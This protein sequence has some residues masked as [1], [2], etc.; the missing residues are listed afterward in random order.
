MWTRLLFIVAVCNIHSAICQQ[1]FLTGHIADTQ[2]NLPL[3]F[4]SVYLSN[5]SF[6]TESDS[7][8]RFKLANIPFGKYTLAASMVGYQTF[9]QAITIDEKP[10][11]PI[12]IKMQVSE[13][14][15]GEVS[16]KAKRDKKWAAQFKIFE[17]EFF[18]N[19]A[20]KKQCKILNSWVLDFEEKPSGIFKATAS[21][22]LAVENRALGYKI[23][24]DLKHFKVSG[25]GFNLQGF[26]RFIELGYDNKKQLEE[27]ERNRDAAFVGSERH[28]LKSLVTHRLKQEGFLVHSVNDKF[29]GNGTALR[30]NQQLGKRLLPFTDSSLVAPTLN[31]AVFTIWLS[32]EIEI[33]NTNEVSYQ[34]TYADAPYPVSWLIIKNN[35]AE[36][37]NE[38]ILGNPS[39]SIWAGDISKR[40]V[41]NMLPNNYLPIQKEKKPTP[42]L[43]NLV[44]Q[45]PEPAIT[46]LHQF[47]GD[48]LKL[49]IRFSK[50]KHLSGILNVSV[51][52]STD[53]NFVET[54]KPI[55]ESMTTKSDKK[56]IELDE[57]VVKEKRKPNAKT[58][59]VAYITPDVVQTSE[60]FKDDVTGNVLTR[61]QDRT[62]GI[63]IVEILDEYGLPQYS[64]NVR[65]SKQ[66]TFLK[67]EP[68][69]ILMNGLPFSQ[70][71]D[72]LR[73]IS[74][75]NI[76]R[77]EVFKTAHALFG[78]RGAGGVINVITKSQEGIEPSNKSKKNEFF[79][80]QP[81][82]SFDS[83]KDYTVG[84]WIADKNKKL[85]IIVTGKTADGQN[86]YVEKNVVLRQR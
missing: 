6:V 12:N 68:P 3:P 71:M 13:N 45:E 56:T 7:L 65:A 19:H 66:S 46:L 70:N 1:N 48:S 59:S 38:G 42:D 58:G 4:V 20:F 10:I 14:V 32:K 28:F 82:S 2:T 81:N 69:L 49:T 11:E 54:D 76:A 72:D 35:Q 27:Y 29:V 67:Y 30:L 61:L 17:N 62:P 33:L 80:Y 37:S 34:N 86:L 44:A 41:A 23:Y 75:K 77:I 51:I 63:R 5:T 47:V 60:D 18:G 52:E 78:S 84:F 64:I 43:D 39:Q 8:G 57:V 74:L 26:V 50:Q 25:N 83:E 40:R 53:S 16:V 79:G 15:L 73:D 85:T 22:P 24:Y 31:P 36:C 9:T 55:E 21:Q